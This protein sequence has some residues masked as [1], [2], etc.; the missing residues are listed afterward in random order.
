MSRGEPRVRFFD[1]WECRVS[2]DTITSVPVSAYGAE[3][4]NRMEVE[5]Y[6]TLRVY[7][8]MPP[9]KP[10]TPRPTF[11]LE[12]VMM[13]HAQAQALPIG[14]T[15]SLGSSILC[16]GKWRWPSSAQVHS[17]RGQNVDAPQIRLRECLAICRK[18]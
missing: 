2:E 7:D 1:G 13:Q 14:E 10:R 9:S 4:H 11:D 18:G 6:L 17:A 5:R 15:T 16:F 3:V 12:M 8:S